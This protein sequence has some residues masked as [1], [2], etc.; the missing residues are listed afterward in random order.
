MTKYTTD[1]AGKSVGINVNDI[2][3]S[4]DDVISKDNRQS[5]WT[6]I[7]LSHQHQK[8]DNDGTDGRDGV[9]LTCDK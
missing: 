2:G 8:A 4:L 7:E 5:Y 3:N 6:M 1:L 9:D